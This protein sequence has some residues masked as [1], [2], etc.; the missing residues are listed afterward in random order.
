MHSAIQEA[1]PARCWIYPE[2]H[3][4]TIGPFIWG[5]QLDPR[6]AFTLNSN[7]WDAWPYATNAREALRHQTRLR[8]KRLGSFLRPY[9]KWYCY[10]RLETGTSPRTLCR[11]LSMLGKADAIVLAMGAEALA[12]IAPEHVFQRAWGAPGDCWGYRKG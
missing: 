10:E 4:A 7:T 1:V 6:G 8:F 2:E 3:L 9:A 5:N 11:S 12:D